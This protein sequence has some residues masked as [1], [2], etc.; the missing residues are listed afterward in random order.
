MWLKTFFATWKLTSTLLYNP[1]IREDV[2]TEI[3]KIYSVP[4]MNIEQR[5]DLHPRLSED[6]KFVSFDSSH[7]S[8]RKMLILSLEK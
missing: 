1:S 3:I 2:K 8:L 4:T 7:D 5:T 6:K